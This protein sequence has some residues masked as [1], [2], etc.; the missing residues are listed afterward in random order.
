MGKFESKKSNCLFAWKLTHRV[1]G[2]CDCKD[3]EE[4]LEVEIK[5]SIVLSACCS[6]I[7]IVAKGKN[8]SHQQKDDG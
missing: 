4:C 3:T 6:Y 7:F 1:S 8:W 5:M 2:E